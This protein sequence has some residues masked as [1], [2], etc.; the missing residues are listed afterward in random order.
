[1][2]TVSMWLLPLV[3]FKLLFYGR[4]RLLEVKTPQANPNMTMVD[5]GRSV[6]VAVSACPNTTRSFHENGVLYRMLKHGFWRI[7]IGKIATV[8]CVHHGGKS[9]ATMQH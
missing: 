8:E 1:M 2:T 6:M 3:V 4:A 7:F 5:H 9:T